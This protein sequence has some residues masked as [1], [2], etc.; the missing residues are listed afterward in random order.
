M[1][2]IVL[3]EDDVQFRT[4]LRMTLERAGHEVVEA[5]NGDEG[6]AQVEH[7]SPDLVITDLVMPEK[8]GLETIMELWQAHPDLPIIAISGGGA[9]VDAEMALSCAQA[10]GAMR[11]FSKPLDREKLLAAVKELVPEP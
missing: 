7:V 9:K 11:T 5:N 10:F 4:M 8:E 3:I 6:I 2:Q 1:A